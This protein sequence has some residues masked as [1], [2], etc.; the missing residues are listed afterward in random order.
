MGQR[1]A[2]HVLSCSHSTTI[3]SVTLS[4]TFLSLSEPVAAK[5]EKKFLFHY[6]FIHRCCS[7]NS[8]TVLSIFIDHLI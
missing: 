4:K 3:P 2:K 7:T 1:H 8:T 5:K 6:D